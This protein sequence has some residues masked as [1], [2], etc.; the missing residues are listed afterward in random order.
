MTPIPLSDSCFIPCAEGQGV[1]GYDG[2]GAIDYDRSDLDSRR[3]VSNLG[4]P[5]SQARIRQGVASPQIHMRRAV[6]EFDLLYTDHDNALLIRPE[7][8]ADIGQWIESSITEPQPVFC[9]FGTRSRP[10]L[11]ANLIHHFAKRQQF[12]SACTF[13]KSP[14][15]GG[16]RKDIDLGLL[17]YDTPIPIM[18][19]DLV[20][21]N[22]SEMGITPTTRHYFLPQRLALPFPRVEMF[23]YGV[24]QTFLSR[25]LYEKIRNHPRPKSRVCGIV[26]AQPFAEVAFDVPPDT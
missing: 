4:S 20:F 5:D 24:A 10:Y 7:F 13:R 16:K 19:S 23:N 8:F 2:M 3:F 14:V 22:N 18:E 26:G 21:A 11:F 15:M 1:I 12:W 17:P 9:H 25:D 6:K